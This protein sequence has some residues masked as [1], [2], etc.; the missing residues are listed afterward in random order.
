[1][2]CNKCGKKLNDNAN[3][4]ASCGT[5]TETVENQEKINTVKVDKKVNENNKINFDNL[6]IKVVIGV[7]LIFIVEL[8]TIKLVAL[9]YEV[10]ANSYNQFNKYNQYNETNTNTNKNKTKEYMIDPNSIQPNY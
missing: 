3:F 8:I 9:K 10:K 1:M 5:K 2:Y 7:V 4:C 6:F